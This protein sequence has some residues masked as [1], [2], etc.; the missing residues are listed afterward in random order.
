MILTYYLKMKFPTGHEIG[1]VRGDQ[2]L[3]RYCYSIA[4]QKSGQPN[5]CPVAGLDVHD[6]LA[7]E[8][9][10]PKEDLVVVFLDDGNTEHV[11]QIDSSSDGEVQKKLIAFLRKNA[12]AFAWVPTDMPEIDV[13][14]MEYRLA[15]DPKCRL[16]KQKVQS[17][18]LER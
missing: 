14:V 8:R 17:Y 13:E 7:E 18:A 3:A 9:D 16:V 12:D 15:V 6:D 4:L 1:E 11:V 2:A 5:L 10:K